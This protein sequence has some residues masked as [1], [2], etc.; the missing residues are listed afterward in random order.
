VTIGSADFPE[1]EILAYVYAGAMKARGV[2]VSVHADIGERPA[3]ITALRDGSIGAVPEY[4]GSILDYLDPSATA[5]APG[6]VYTS[7]QHVA[8]A[9]GFAV[10][11]YAPA[12]DIDTITVT[13]A[14]AAK[15]HLTTIASIKT[16]AGELSLGAPEPLL[17]LPYGVPA[18]KSAYGVV[19]RRFVPLPAGGT[20][21]QTALRNGTIGAADIFSTDPSISKYGFVSLTDTKHIFAAQNVVPLFKL[22]VL[23]EPMTQACNAVSAQL[24]T[25]SLRNLV[26]KVADGTS[27][28][29]AAAQWLSSAGLG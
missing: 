16:V 12:Q 7:L 3:Y 18:L 6:A 27:P 20:V 22:N 14:T 26:G 28:A 4:S 9:Q 15:Y 10:T 2:T 21:T 8:A 11:G 13:K 24:T 23:T 19:F 5:K 1:D 17:T 25:A 29:S